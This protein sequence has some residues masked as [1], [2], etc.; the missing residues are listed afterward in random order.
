M[1]YINNKDLIPL[2]EDY[3]KTGVISNELGKSFYIIAKRLSQ[4]SNWCNYTYRN[5]MINTAVLTCVKYI[6]NFDLN[7][8][9][10]PFSYITQ[11]CH[12]AFVAFVKKEKKHSQ[13]KDTCYKNID[14]LDERHNKF[15]NKAI[16]YT[17]LIRKNNETKKIHQ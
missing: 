6:H 9:Q 12:N 3:K 14:L 1:N 5:D 2:L 13:I 7:K 8:S 11:I 10:N 16:D 15:L 4:K 17:V